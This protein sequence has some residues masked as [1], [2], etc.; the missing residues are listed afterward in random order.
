MRYLPAVQPLMAVNSRFRHRGRLALAPVPPLEPSE[1]QRQISE[2]SGQ[3]IRLPTPNRLLTVS[4]D[5]LPTESRHIPVVQDCA[6]VT[7]PPQPTWAATPI[8]PEA[9]DTAKL[10]SIPQAILDG[11]FHHFDFS[12]HMNQEA[13]P[14]RCRLIHP[15]IVRNVVAA[16]LQFD[17]V[18]IR[19]KGQGQLIG[20][21]F[22][23]AGFCSKRLKAVDQFEQIIHRPA[24][25]EDPFSGGAR[26]TILSV[27][28]SIS[29]EATV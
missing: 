15:G 19:V 8:S 16:P 10:I 11:D 7:S 6:E 22:P 14:C 24:P 12:L 18:T 21:Q 29:R 23:G 27:C 3:L 5:D 1:V 2:S 20:T 17:D 9:Q 28:F 13:L 25:K 26:S 4:A